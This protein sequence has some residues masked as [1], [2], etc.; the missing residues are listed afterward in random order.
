M[1]EDYAVSIDLSV[2]SLPSRNNYMKTMRALNIPY[3]LENQVLKF[4]H[5][6]IKKVTDA[7]NDMH[8]KG[9]K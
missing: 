5:K 1:N 8:K 4:S 9:R 7:L 6:N 2:L 3:L